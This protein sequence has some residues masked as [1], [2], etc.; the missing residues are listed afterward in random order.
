MASYLMK[1]VV[2][3]YLVL[4]DDIIDPD[5]HN[6]IV[7]CFKVCHDDLLTICTKLYKEGKD[8]TR[9]RALIDEYG[10]MLDKLKYVTKDEYVY[11]DYVNLWIDLCKKLLEIDKEIYV[12]L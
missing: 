1:E 8:V 12:L 11:A 7:L 9:L 5:L 3:L 10:V 4:L 6:N 2:K